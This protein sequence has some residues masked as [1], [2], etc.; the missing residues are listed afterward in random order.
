[1]KA[2]ESR[3]ESRSR[4]FFFRR[5]FLLRGMRQ[6]LKQQNWREHRTKISALHRSTAG[7]Q[8]H[9]ATCHLGAL[10]RPRK[11][12]DIAGNGLAGIFPRIK[13]EITIEEGDFWRNLQDAIDTAPT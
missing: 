11:K 5:T 10:R 9:D 7:H 12:T 3:I 1:M 4:I 6:L 13:P 8:P 2:L